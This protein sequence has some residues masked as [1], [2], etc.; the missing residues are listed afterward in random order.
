[1]A[2]NVTEWTNSWEK[3]P[4]KPGV[5]V[6]VRRGGSFMTRSVEELKLTSRRISTEPGEANLLTGFRIVSDK[7]PVPATR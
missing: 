2:G 6:P 4:N 3:H 7:P 5:L 1:M